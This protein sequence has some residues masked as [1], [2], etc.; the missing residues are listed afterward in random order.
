MGAAAASSRRRS[1]TATERDVRAVEVVV[2]AIGKTGRVLVA[3]EG[4]GGNRILLVRND[5]RA[6]AD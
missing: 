3:T 4:V 1:L 5:A 6:D 2:A